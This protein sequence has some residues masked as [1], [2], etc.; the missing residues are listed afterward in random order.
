MDAAYLLLAP[1]IAIGALAV[2][3]GEDS[4]RERFAR[5]E[6]VTDALAADEPGSGSPDFV[7]LATADQPVWTV[8]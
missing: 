4:L 1:F 8:V 2:S 5:P 7:D 3:M 6:R